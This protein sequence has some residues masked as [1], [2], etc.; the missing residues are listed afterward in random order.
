MPSQQ[1]VGP[2][3]QLLVP[4]QQVPAPSP[5]FRSGL[6]APSGGA[7]PRSLECILQTLPWLRIEERAL[8]GGKLIDKNLLVSRSEPESAPL[9][10]KSF[11]NQL[12]KS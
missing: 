10:C 8:K 9:P 7:S 12:K 6:P 3:E 2:R 1:S 4:H 11:V 5:V